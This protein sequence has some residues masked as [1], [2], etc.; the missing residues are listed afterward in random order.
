MLSILHAE[1]LHAEFRG[2][3]LSTF[4]TCQ[5]LHRRD[6]LPV[7][8][9]EEGDRFPAEVFLDVT[10]NNNNNDGWWRPG[11]NVIKQYRGNLLR[12]F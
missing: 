8:P 10:L 4:R 11:A 5:N 1:C 12:Y 6:V 2:F 9:V 7:F 3:H